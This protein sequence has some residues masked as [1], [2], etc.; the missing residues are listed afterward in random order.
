MAES[1]AGPKN[2]WVPNPDHYPML[3]MKLGKLVPWNVR[4]AH[5][6]CNNIDFSLRKRIRTLLEKDLSLSF[7]Q[8]AE[9][10]N[11]RKGA[12]GRQMVDLGRRSPSARRTCR[13]GQ[14][15]QV[16]G[17]DPR[18]WQHSSDY[19]WVKMRWRVMRPRPRLQAQ[20]GAR[21]GAGWPVPGGR[22]KT[23]LQV[24]ASR[25][26]AHHATSQ[27][28]TRLAARISAPAQT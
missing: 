28:T 27:S 11:T 26:C 12:L 3:N 18:M 20:P 10:R 21:G 14:T 7:E 6:W 5:V 9:Q 2:K 4:L 16:S 8:L 15:T 22:G 1:E 24:Q 23:Q 13:K 19:V 17:P 25:E